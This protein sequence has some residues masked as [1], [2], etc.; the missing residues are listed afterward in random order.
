MQ[1]RVKHENEDGTQSALR[2]IRQTTGEATFP[3]AIDATPEPSR[4]TISAVMA[5][6]GRRG[7][8]K[9]GPARAKALSKAKRKAIAKKAARARWSKG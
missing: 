2:V 9:G 7:G 8:Q 5:V 4:E 1:K 3:K 6:L